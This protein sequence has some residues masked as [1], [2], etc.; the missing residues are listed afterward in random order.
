MYNH[1]KAFTLI[2]LLV[3]VLIIVIL[4]AIVLPQ[5]HKAVYKARAIQLV[6]LVNAYKTALDIY[7]LAHGYSTV[8]FYSSSGSPSDGFPQAELD[9]DF[10]QQEAIKILEYYKGK[11]GTQFL[12][13]CEQSAEYTGCDIG[14][15]GEIIEVSINK[16]PEQPTWS[17]SC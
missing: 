2:E 5:Y 15:M 10:S 6:S 1:K 7:I 14:I 16:N 4:A 17:T 3:V 13:S 8:K 12:V 11:E 9:I